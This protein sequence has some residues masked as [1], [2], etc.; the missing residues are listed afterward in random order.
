MVAAFALKSAGQ[1]AAK[2]Q[3]FVLG[4][5]VSVDVS[6]RSQEDLVDLSNVPPEILEKFKA[7]YESLPSRQKALGEAK[8]VE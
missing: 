1:L 8:R 5:K 2:Q 7:A 3:E 6:V 4:K